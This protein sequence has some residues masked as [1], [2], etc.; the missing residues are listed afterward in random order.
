MRSVFQEGIMQLCTKCRVEICESGL[1]MSR[2]RRCGNL[3]KISDEIPILAPKL[4]SSNEGYDPKLYKELL[5]L[6]ENNYWF[7]SRNSL[8][9][10]VIRKYIQPFTSFLEIG[11]GTGYV[12]NYLTTNF[13]ANF[14]GSEIYLQGLEQSKNRLGDRATLFQMDATEMPF[15]AAFDVIGAFDVIEHIED[16]RKCLTEIN[17]ALKSN[18]KMILTVP[19]HMFLWS[20]MDELGKHQRRYSKRELVEKVESAGFSVKYINSFM[21]ILMPAMLISRFINKNN[22]AV[23]FDILAE[24]RVGAVVNSI[25]KAILYIEI[26][27]SKL[28]VRWPFG[29]S[30]II[31]AEKQEV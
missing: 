9:I 4:A 17:K 24:L 27:L 28:G 29:G 21:S 5:Q 31:A 7:S 11:C 3:S 30:L 20:K 19:Q 10:W 12:I 6:E 13:N 25:L 22:T 16:D 14:F 26:I 15:V 1:F 18:G 2:C 8:I 23:D